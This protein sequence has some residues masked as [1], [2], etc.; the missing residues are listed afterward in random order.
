MRV[1][2]VGAGLGGLAA[3]AGLHRNGHEVTVFERAPELREAGTAIVVLPTGVRALDELG[4]AGYLRS[5]PTATGHGGLRDW[6]GRPLLV[7]D[8]G[9]A[10]RQVGAAVTVSRTELHRSLRA[11]LPPELLRTATAVDDLRDEPGGV[12]LVGGGRDVAVADAVV[13]ADGIGSV[14]RARLFPDHPGLR[15]A[16]RL[17]LRGTASLPSG[18][19]VDGL[20]TN[21]L[22]DRRTGA[23]FGLFPLPGGEVYWFTDCALTGPPPAPEQAREQML[24]LMADWHPAV[25]AIIAATAPSEVYVDAIARLAVPLPSFAAGRIALL[26]D[27]AHA[28]TPDLG[29][30]ASQ[31]FED[32]A[33]LTRRLAGAVPGE[34]AGRLLRYDAERRPPTSRMMEASSR[35]GWLMS[36]TGVTAW[37]RDTLLRA[38]PRR[39]ATRR[40]ATMWQ[41]PT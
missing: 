21:I 3:A 33:A 15:R 27:A 37:T 24:A 1:A 4:L 11:P 19:A 22:V 25:P 5:V 9:R 35:Q 16:G 39:L 6:R 26:G 13:V 2:V 28:M 29:Q 30:G 8:L 34:V 12:R 17:D 23:L 40:L 38:V 20:M 36:R 10:Q 14:L 7:T 31:A 18:L 41:V 32:A